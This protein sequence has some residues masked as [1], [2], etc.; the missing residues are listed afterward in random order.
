MKVFPAAFSGFLIPELCP[1]YQ[2][3]RVEQRVNR[4]KRWRVEIFLDVAIV[5]QA[6]FM[7]YLFVLH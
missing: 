3:V 6:V 1:E 2:R 5:F 7:S 4:G